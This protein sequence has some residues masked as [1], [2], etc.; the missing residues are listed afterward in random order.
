MM[1]EV[2]EGKEVSV[3]Q[4]FEERYRQ[5]WDAPPVTLHSPIVRAMLVLIKL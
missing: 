3:V 1:F 5:K 2:S 4:Y